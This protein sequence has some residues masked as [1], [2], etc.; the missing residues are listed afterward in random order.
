M[1][2]TYEY[3]DDGRL[4]VEAD[5]SHSIVRRRDIVGNVTS[6]EHVSGPP[7]T[8]TAAPSS[9]SSSEHPSD[10]TPEP[11]ANWWN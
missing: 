9:P 2:R 3:D 6:H 7:T 11:G 4:L 5:G 8:P 10:S 1:K